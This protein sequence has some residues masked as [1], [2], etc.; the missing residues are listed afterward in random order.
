MSTRITMLLPRIDVKEGLLHGDGTRRYGRCVEKIEIDMTTATNQ[1]AVAMLIRGQHQAE[2]YNMEQARR[3][4]CE[5]SE[6]ARLSK[7]GFVEAAATMVQTILMDG[8]TNNQS[9]PHFLGQALTTLDAELDRQRDSMTT[10]RTTRK[11]ALPI[12][13]PRL[14]LRELIE[15]NL[16]QFQ[17][18]QDS[19]MLAETRVNC[20]R[21]LAAGAWEPAV[22]VARI[23]SQ[24]AT[25]LF[26]ADHWWNAVFRVR[27]AT[28]L[29]RMQEVVRARQ[30]LDKVASIFDE[31]TDYSDKG[32]DVFKFQ[33]DI[34]ATAQADIALMTA[35]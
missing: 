11:D 35:K 32:N 20:D 21:H 12:M 26:G 25:E 6:Q 33:R 9:Q 2:R 16:R 27:L 18:R 31:W 19:L 29:L 1:D 24:N 22:S 8:L 17:F 13:T 4:N 7:D 5:A 28:A 15:E 14:D 34:L 30:A 23:G 10:A 3:L